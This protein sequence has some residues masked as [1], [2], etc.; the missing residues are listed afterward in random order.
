MWNNENNS[1]IHINTFIERLAHYQVRPDDISNYLDYSVQFETN[2]EIE[3]KISTLDSML[4]DFRINY[5]DLSQ[6]IEDEINQLYSDVILLKS[7]SYDQTF[8]LT[9]RLIEE[10]GKRFHELEFTGTFFDFG[11]EIGVIVGKY[12]NNQNLGTKKTDFLS[13]I[14]EGFKIYQG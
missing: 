13:G 7:I 9:Q 4:L 1:N 5:P 10:F 12:F 11:R 2:S 6:Q 3:D 8:E 14:D